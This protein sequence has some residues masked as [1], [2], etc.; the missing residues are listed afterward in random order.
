MRSEFDIVFGRLY[1]YI[2]LSVF[3]TIGQYLQQYDYT[4]L[5]IREKVI[6]RQQKQLNEFFSQ[7]QDATI[8]FR[9]DQVKSGETSSESESSSMELNV[10]LQN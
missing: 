2:V 10:L 9:V 5:I 8:L 3:F 6:E 4:T 1:K 7:Q